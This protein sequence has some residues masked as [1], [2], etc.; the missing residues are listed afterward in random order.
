LKSKV[1]GLSSH[2]HLAVRRWARE[3][4]LPAPFLATLEQ[5][6]P[7]VFCGD[8]LSEE[9]ASELLADVFPRFNLGDPEARL[10][11]RLLNEFSEDE[12]SW[13]AGERVDAS[14]K[15]D[16]VLNSWDNDD[17]VDGR[18][19]WLSSQSSLSSRP[20]VHVTSGVLP[21]NQ[22]ISE[23]RSVAKECHYFEALVFMGPSNEELAVIQLHPKDG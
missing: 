6:A 10:F 11:A 12:T 2:I 16:A 14:E 3:H 17:P 9:L 20:T 1:I 22:F 19:M 23:L 8:G 7:W 5:D 15:I 13:E 4:R 21:P 18:A